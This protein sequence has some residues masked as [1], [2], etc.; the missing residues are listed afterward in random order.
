MD[1]TFEDYKGYAEDFLQS[2]F[3][4]DT[5]KNFRCINPNHIDSNPSMGYDKNQCRAHCFSCEQSYDLYDMVGIYFNITD[6][7]EQFR[8]VQELYDRSVGVSNTKITPK[9]KVEKVARKINTDDIKKYIQKCKD[10]VSKTD[11]FLNR[12]LTVETIERC[13]LGYDEEE[14]AVVIPYSK[15][16]DYYQRRSVKDKR[17]YKPKTED[18]GEEPLYNAQALRLKTRKPIFIVES[19]ICAMSIIQC[20]GMAVALN[21][22]GATKLYNMIKGK[23]PLGTLLLC[24]DNDDA[25]RDNTIKIKN[26]L[27]ELDVKYL[28]VNI[29]DDCKDPNELLMRDAKRLQDNVSRAIAE[30][31]KLTAT[32]FDSI[33][34]EQLIKMK[35][36]PRIWVVNDLLSTGLTILAS[37][38][39]AGKSWMMLQLTQ[40]VAE[41]EEFLGFKTNKYDVEYMALEDEPQRI[42][43]R[44]LLQRKDKPLDPGC[45]ITNKAPTLDS[46][47][48]LDV[49]AEKLE[50]NPKIKLFIIDTLQKVRKVKTNAKADSNAYAQDYE[51]I[52]ALKE[53]ADD[54]KIA[55]VVVHHTRKMVDELDPFANILGSTALNGVV[56]TMLVINNRKK[57]EVVL[58]YKGRD[59]APSSK[60][61]EFDD[62][63]KGKTYKWNIVGSPEEQEK[64]RQEREY[65]GNPLVRTIK[66]LLKA[67]PSGWRGNTTEFMQAVYDVTGEV[68]AMNS[69]HVGRELNALHSKLYADGIQ[70]DSGQSKKSRYHSFSYVPKIK[71][72]QM[73]RSAYQTTFDD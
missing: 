54:N 62:D 20:G 32:K 5:R 23:K 43:E 10:C 22:T 65:T 70:H 3:G 8:K 72:W 66:E 7:G 37:P 6:K 34:L 57:D 73:G 45:Y 15:A 27:Q 33:P 13:N 42:C 59:I 51:E 64:K 49:L 35:F 4:V 46:D 68:L 52:G 28:I 31:K 29:A 9:K 55:I 41:G 53:F 36:P 40:A 26:K 50:D 61:I 21:G 48:L 12:G 44:T 30:G 56:D 17:F 38:A 16:M 1:K 47:A 60:I 2:Y 11:Y 14:D 58:H 39:K 25:G 19:A 63:T 67:N 69:T 71:K 24:L 18:A